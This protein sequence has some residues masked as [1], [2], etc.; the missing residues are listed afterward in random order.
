MGP[1]RDYLEPSMKNSFNARSTTDDVLK[2]IDLTGKTVLL[3]GCNSGLGF[4]T[5]RQLTARGASVI[6]AA[7]NLKTAQEACANAGGSTVPLACDLSNF[8]SV[9]QAIAEIRASGRRIDIVI[10]NAGIMALPRLEQIYGLEKQFVVNYLSHF[11]LIT[12]ILGMI[13]QHAGAR[14]VILASSAHTRAR[15]AGI[16]FDNLSG[17]RDYKPWVLY[18]QSNVARILF[19][20]ALSRRL[21]GAGITVNS[22]HPGVIADTNLSRHLGVLMRALAPVARLFTKTIP[23]GAA[24][25]CYL[26]AH[27]EVAGKTGQYFSDCKV[28]EPSLAARDDVMGERLWALSEQL[29]AAHRG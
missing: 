9:K 17:E 24:T 10:A 7:R 6:A 21:S 22:L 16:E 23:Q 11:M 15:P 27:P 25:Q 29:V 2:G 18:G 19:A 4:E 3:T 13:P 8:A 14:I 20:R 28:A 1:T 5:L 12:G 26:A